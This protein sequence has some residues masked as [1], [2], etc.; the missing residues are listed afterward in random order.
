MA[1]SE[2]RRKC[3]VNGETRTKASWRIRRRKYRKK[4]DAA[5]AREIKRHENRGMAA[6]ACGGENGGGGVAAMARRDQRSDISH[7]GVINEK[8]ASARS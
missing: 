8:K 5:A 2:N 7:R 3:G 6:K 4:S 1:T